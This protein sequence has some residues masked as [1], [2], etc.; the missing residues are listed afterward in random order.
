MKIGASGT[1]LSLGDDVL[2]TWAHDVITFRAEPELTLTIA[3]EA[4]L[5]D[6]DDVDSFRSVA[7]TRYLPAE[8][9]EI[10]V[11]VDMPRANTTSEADTPDVSRPPQHEDERTIDMPWHALVPRLR[12]STIVIACVAALVCLAL[13][14]TTGGALAAIAGVIAGAAGLG[15]SLAWRGLVVSRRRRLESSVGVDIDAEARVAR[16]VAHA[17]SARTVTASLEDQAVVELTQ[18]KGIGPQYAQLLV[19]AG[20]RSIDALANL[21]AGQRVAL[22][23]ALGRQ[24]ERVAREGWIE[25]ARRIVEARGN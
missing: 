7:E 18:I 2:G 24:G 25:Q 20:V 23:S 12:S 13:S 14:V 4:W 10:S 5:I 8:I 17:L 22:E 16:A 6:V 11:T 15:A 3:G 21:T 1:R 9:P 19:D